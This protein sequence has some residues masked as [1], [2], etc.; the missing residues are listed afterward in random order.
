[1]KLDFQI[2]ETTETQNISEGSASYREL[3]IFTVK[4]TQRLKRTTAELHMQ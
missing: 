2:G 4:S 1:M 3:H